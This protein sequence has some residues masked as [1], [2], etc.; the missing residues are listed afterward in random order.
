MSRLGKFLLIAGFGL[1]PL[2]VSIAWL[3]IGASQESVSSEYWNVAPW[4]VI[5][6]GVCSTITLAISFI[7]LAVLNSTKGSP[8]QNRRR[9]FRTFA[10][11]VV[12]VGAGIAY[13]LHYRMFR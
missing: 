12:L 11:L 8:E 3:L 4:M 13:A 9:A 1:L 6:G 10:V 7:T 5:L 2:W